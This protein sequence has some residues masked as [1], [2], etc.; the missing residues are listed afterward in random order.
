MGQ[1]EDLHLFV[2]VVD[3]NGIGKAASNLH[4][5]KSAVSRRLSLL[6]SKYGLR[7]IDRDKGNW[8][9]TPAGKE[10][11]QR[12][13]QLVNDVTELDN[14]FKFTE[15][16]YA[17]PLNVT[18][19]DEFGLTSLKSSIV[20]FKKKYPQIQLTVDF[21]NRQVDLERENYDLAIRISD[22]LS[23][24]L[25]V[26]QIGNTEHHLYAS[27]DYV[28]KM[29]LPESIDQLADHPLLHHGAARRAT[30]VFLEAKA[31]RILEF[32]PVLNSNSGQFL[33]EA[34]LQGLGIARL[35]DFI[36]REA[37][38]HEGLV[39]ILPEVQIAT[40]S[41]SLVYSSKLRLNRRVRLFIE[42]MKQACQLLGCE[43]SIVEPDVL[44]ESK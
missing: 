13:I 12:A 37:L 33:L 24:A 20:Q 18:V 17:G 42:E 22:E 3:N 9:V 11:Y 23:P 27:S 30:W 36:A 40:A 1:L 34:T 21:D 35:P 26:H 16:S 4:I 43:T 25:L 38:D 7:L 19:A 44:Q 28:R 41:I 32:N 15:Q 10:L 14:D 2:T 6:E 39:K 5:A 31:E 8:E 29:G